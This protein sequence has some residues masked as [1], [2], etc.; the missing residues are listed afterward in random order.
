MQ[1][2]VVIPT[3][4]RDDVLVTTLRQLVLQEGVAF[5]IVVVDQNTETLPVL[6]RFLE[7]YSLQVPLI[8]VRM[9]EKSASAARNRGVLAA[10]GDVVVFLDDDVLIEDRGFLQAHYR[11]YFDQSISVVAGQVLG[12][13]RG[14]RSHRHLFSHFVDAGWLYFP[15][16]YDARSTQP[17]V[18]I[19]ANLSV[20]RS[21]ALSLGG[22]DER[23]ERGTF[24]EESDFLQRL[25]KS[26]RAGV[27]DPMAS[28]VHI[29][30]PTGGIRSWGSQKR[31]PLHHLVGEWYFI[32]RHMT[33]ASLPHHMFALL[34]NQRPQLGT[35]RDLW[36]IPV[37]FFRSTAALFLAVRILACGPLILCETS[38]MEQHRIHL[39]RDSK[40][41]GVSNANPGNQ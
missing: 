38:V 23:F 19:S 32:F 40:K 3:V 27:F 8:H 15:L 35:V 17:G 12:L 28:L 13:D 2:S 4:G 5:E 24:R 9:A 31:R 6:K 22:M 1:V 18:G 41:Y 36:E 26:G 21:V 10:A 7:G 14:T 30:H 33:I 37:A 20:R 29:G 11:N 39:Q 16:A 34:R 25:R